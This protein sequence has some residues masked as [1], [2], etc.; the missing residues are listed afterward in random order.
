MGTDV[1]GLIAEGIF[2]RK[3]IVG[4]ELE[5]DF[6]EAGCEMFG[7]KESMGSNFV[8][9]SCLLEEGLPTGKNNF[10]YAYCGS[11]Y[12]LLKEDQA[13]LLTKNAFDALKV[14]LC[15]CKLTLFRKVVSSLEGL[16]AV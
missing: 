10:N 1:R 8:V 12:H 16:L 5:R 11:V 3:N 7:D 9:G 4:L 6:V 2:E 15:V 14:C 13:R